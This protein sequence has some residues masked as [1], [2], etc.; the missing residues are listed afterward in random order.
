MVGA[1]NWPVLLQQRN[2]PAAP[3]SIGVLIKISLDVADKEVWDAVH[4]LIIP[5]A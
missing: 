3:G 4:D 1:T 2:V 5:F